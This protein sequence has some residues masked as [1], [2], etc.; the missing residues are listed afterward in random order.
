MHGQKYV[1]LEKKHNN[2][3]H[4]NAPRSTHKFE[5]HGIEFTFS[6]LQLFQI[7]IIGHKDLEGKLQ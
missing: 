2:L 5:T 4:N 1:C 6:N 3:S 7:F